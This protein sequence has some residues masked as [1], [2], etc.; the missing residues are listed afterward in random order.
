MSERIKKEPVNFV[1]GIPS[2]EAL[3][4]LIPLVSE[5]YAK[6]IERYGIDVLQ[7]GHFSG[8]K[9]L[10]DLLG[11]MHHVDPERVIVGN[12]G[13]E[14]ISL[15]LKSLPLASNILVE[16]TTYDRVI[17][18]AKRYGHNLIGV[19]LTSEGLDLH[20]LREVVNRIRPAAFYGI[21]FHHNPTGITY[22][23]EN[24][25]SVEQICREEGIPCIWDICYELLRYDGIQNEPISVSEWGPILVNSFTKTISP[26]TK[27]GYIVLPK[28]DVDH[29]ARIVA[30]S[31]L[32]PNLP[33]QAFV[34]DFIR[35]G[36]Y[37]DFLNYLR[38]LYK[39]RMDA[40]NS[41]LSVSF[42]G[43]FPVTVSGG[44]FVS[45][46]LSRVGSDKEQSFIASAKQAG[47]T[48]S[49]AWDAVAPNRRDE[50]RKQGLFIR[51]PFPHCEPERIEWGVSK[52]KEIQSQ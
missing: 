15:F 11:E 52:L 33:T 2:E 44:F 9:L 21:P 6:A 47:V 10:R 12:G 23:K 45:L 26:G 5:G 50:V 35:S 25:D 36:K 42:P 18:D 24:R 27:C 20:R 1:R 17:F 40:L 43:A 13:M 3:L 49:A 38:S 32:N 46:S 31:R 51:L 14:V 7:Y 30:H 37:E 16:E 28:K 29:M 22:S 41:S 8:F 34:A 39:P 19:E 48:I 4:H